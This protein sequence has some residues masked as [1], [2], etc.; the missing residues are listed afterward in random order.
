MYYKK[1]VKDIDN[2]EDQQFSI[3]CTINYLK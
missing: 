2:I 1:V 3:S